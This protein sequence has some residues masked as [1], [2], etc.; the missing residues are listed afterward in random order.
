MMGQ[1][2]M[3]LSH[4]GFL[5]RAGY[6]A[7]DDGYGGVDARWDSCYLDK[8]GSVSAMPEPELNMFFDDEVID[9][10]HRRFLEQV[11]V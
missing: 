3:C 8:V 6:Q 11:R 5:T 4:N 1:P 2:C 10:Q 9:E 7:V